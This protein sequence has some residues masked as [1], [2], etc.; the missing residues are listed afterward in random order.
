LRPDRH[1]IAVVGS[2]NQDLVVELPR[3]PAPGE[4][5]HGRRVSFFPGGKGAN[6]AVAAAR[7]GAE[8]SLFGKVG[9][10]PFGPRLLDALR[11]SG[12]EAGG[13]EIEPDTASGLAI[14]W[15]DDTGNNAIALGA[16]ANGCV[17]S[18]Y[19][20]RY[21]DR[22]AEA[23]V[24]L[25]QLEIPIETVGFLLRAL[26]PTKP[27]VILDPAPAQDLTPLP[28]ER[29]DILTPNEHELH[30]ISEC[31]DIGSGV[32][33]LLDAGVANIVCTLGE[34]GA[35]W[36]SAE[37]APRRF[38]SPHVRTVDTTAAGDAFNG[39]LAWAIRSRTLDEAI[40]FAVAAGALATTVR[41]AQ[42]SLP[43]REDVTDLFRSQPSQLAA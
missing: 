15:I 29:I 14:I 25:L 24:L 16:G 20:E 5:L 9:D 19:I 34:D 23:D 8:A 42:P 6:Q 41:G 30:T 18:S 36:A 10:D 4:T 1:S 22:I 7:L 38:A 21:L 2:I 11:S 35:I 3:M 17:D 32:Q 37:R 40:R 33:R 12:V 43:N 31:G 13:V 28:L 39:A 27:L 26:P